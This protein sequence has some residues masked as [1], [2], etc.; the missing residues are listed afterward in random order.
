MCWLDTNV[1]SGG[2]LVHAKGSMLAR[3]CDVEVIPFEIRVVKEKWLVVALALIFTVTDN[4]YSFNNST[5]FERYCHYHLIYLIYKM[6][7]CNNILDCN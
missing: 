5:S 7:Y 1:N 3:I 6:A 2:F 4:K